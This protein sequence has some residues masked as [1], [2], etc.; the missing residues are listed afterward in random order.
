MFFADP[1]AILAPSV[2]MARRPFRALVTNLDYGV[3]CQ[4]RTK[5]SCATA[6][7]VFRGLSFVGG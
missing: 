1:F 7:S 2:L 6:P 3:A 4:S 5:V